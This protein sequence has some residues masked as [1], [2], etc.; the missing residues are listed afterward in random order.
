[1]YL[2][3]IRIQNFKSLQDLKLD[4]N[5]HF[6]L[7]L[8]DNGFGKSSI[9]KAISLGL[10]SLLLGIK[11][12]KTTGIQQDDIRVKMSGNYG[13]NLEWI[14][15]TPTVIDC[16]LNIN[17]S[18][19]NWSRT[20]ETERGQSKTIENNSSVKKYLANLLNTENSILPILSYQSDS[21]VW[22][23]RRSRTP[24]I[25]KSTGIDR[26]TGYIGCLEAS[27][28]VKTIENWCLQMEVSAY[29]YK[30]SIPEYEKFKETIAI[31]M[32]EMCN[33]KS[34]PKIL[35][36]AR[37][38]TLVYSEDT[39]IYED[40]HNL[41]AGYQSLLWMIIDI[42]YRLAHLNPY[43][44]EI[45]NALGIVL[46]DEIDMHLH[47]NWQW[48]IVNALT[49]TFPNLQ[50]IVTT[51]SPIIIS[52]CSNA[53]IIRLYEN[54]KA[55]D[56]STSYAF[57]VDDVLEFRQGSSNIPPQLR[58]LSREFDIALAKH[59]SREACEIYLEMTKLY[60]DDNS[61]VKNAKLDLDDCC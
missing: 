36:D 3:S 14:Y 40:I 11:G 28:D 9:L 20:R 24:D 34:M 27:T 50:F 53:K 23:A 16:S 39:K 60:G 38:G 29:Q 49:K 31:F 13:E 37:K 7:I 25:L 35:H 15:C 26:R 6:N 30:K 17:D 44:Q 19:L 42:A 58:Q 1:M 51:H 41:S 2:D 33:L 59:N 45:R 12:V 4:F 43:F 21:R 32:R 56:I 46:I 54:Q 22:A 57:S 10:N 48:K 52:S 8:G 47:P 55:S 5:S 61:V 18:L